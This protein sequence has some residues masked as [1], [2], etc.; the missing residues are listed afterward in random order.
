MADTAETIFPGE[1]LVP[2]GVARM[3]VRPFLAVVDAA[4]RARATLERWRY[5]QGACPACHSA[6]HRADCVLTQ[7]AG[8]LFA[9]L[10]VA[11]AKGNGY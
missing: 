4:K 8:D 3:R 9:A 11:E 10:T 5:A 6:I 2:S 1:G 7:I